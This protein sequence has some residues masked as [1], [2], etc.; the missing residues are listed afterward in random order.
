MSQSLPRGISRADILAILLVTTAVATAATVEFTES[1]TRARVART[2]SDLRELAVAIEA[3]EIDHLVPPNDVGNGWPWYLPNAI[4]TPVAY[5]S[6]IPS[7]PF[8]L[9][10]HWG[11]PNFY[12][13]RHRYVNYIAGR[14]RWCDW[15]VPFGSCDDGVATGGWILSVRRFHPLTGADDWNEELMWLGAWKLSGAGPDGSSSYPFFDGYL[16]YDPTNGT[17]STGDIVHTERLGPV[18]P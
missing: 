12:S 6:E 11:T 7:D 18:L 17:I 3:Y 15:G 1:L 14:D 16:L 5:L 2:Q 9:A 13:R 4:T 10:S 8:R